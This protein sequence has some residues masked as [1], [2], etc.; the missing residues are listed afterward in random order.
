MK[1][2]KIFVIA[3]L[4]AASYTICTDAYAGVSF[5]PG[6][7]TKSAG[8]Q[9]QANHCTGYNLRNK[10]C[11]NEACA[12]GWNCESCHNARGTFYACTPRKCEDGYT[13]GLTSCPTCQQY[14]YKGFAGNRICGKCTA[15]SNCSSSGSQSFTYVNSV[16]ISG[17]N[18]NKIEKTGY[19]P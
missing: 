13:P 1:L 2:K 5:L 12:V 11:E 15:I 18:I 14:S 3:A 6:S 8:R 4:I 16:N 10:K 9:V 7:G 17:K 19:K